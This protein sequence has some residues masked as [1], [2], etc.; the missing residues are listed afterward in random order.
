MR[1]LSAVTSCFSDCN[2]IRHN[3]ILSHYLILQSRSMCVGMCVCEGPP[4]KQSQLGSILQSQSVGAPEITDISP[5]VDTCEVL[6]KEK[7][8]VIHSDKSYC[9]RKT[10]FNSFPLCLISP[11][12]QDNDGVS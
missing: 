6:E 12:K 4:E 3:L 2:P 8:N 10:M 9:S 5:L 1:L 7:K 11:T